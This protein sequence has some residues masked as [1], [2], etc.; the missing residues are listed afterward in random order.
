MSIRDLK[1]Y[2]IL[3]EEDLTGIQAKGYLLPS[4]E[5]QGQGSFDREG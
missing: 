3:K 4:Q 1:T 2:E 5:E